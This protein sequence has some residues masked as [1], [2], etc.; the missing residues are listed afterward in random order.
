M[1]K[2]LAYIV[3][4]PARLDRGSRRE[5]HYGLSGCGG[6]ASATGPLDRSLGRR[7]RDLETPRQPRRRG[8][9]RARRDEA[10]GSFRGVG[11]ELGAEAS[12]W[13]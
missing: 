11:K 8:H 9:N 12:L 1:R 2:S 4:R 10:V 3:I 7:K 13:L 6:V 5:P